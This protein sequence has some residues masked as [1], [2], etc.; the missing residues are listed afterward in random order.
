MLHDFIA[1]NQD[2]I[3]AQT[4][5]RVRDRPWPSVSPYELEH[6][7]PLFLTQLSETL[8]LESTERPFPSDV[9]GASAARHGGDLLRLGF[10]V[11]QVVHDYGDVCQAVTEVAV[12]QQAPITVEE[13]HTLN[14]CLDT[15]IAEAVTE[16]SRITAESRAAEEVERLGHAAHE[17]RDILNTAVLG[18]HALKRGA[19]AVNGSTGALLGRSLMKL[20]DVIDRTLAEVR[21][22]SGDRQRHRLVIV[23]FIDEV[24]AAAVLHA[25]YRG[26]DFTVE[27]I[28][29]QLA[30]SADEPL[31]TSAVM[32]LLHN[33]F[34]NT[35][36]G[37]HIVLR[38]KAKDGML[39]IEIEDE[40]GGIPESKSDLF[41]AFGDRRGRDRSGLGLGLSIARRAARAHEGDIHVRNMPGKG[42]VF[43]V[44]IPLADEVAPAS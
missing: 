14:R 23:D 17:L 29:P 2:A 12:E 7:V 1:L 4:R 28:D 44:D 38:A 37:G 32:N 3:I 30:V 34:K 11:S 25:E 13:F 10:N 15:A 9:I 22:A 33:A 5:K 26:V 19:V 8:R 18:F 36:L 31:L 20:R 21:L 27:P 39:V 42:C 35:P 24:S 43:S 40:C 6:G 16:H 41:E